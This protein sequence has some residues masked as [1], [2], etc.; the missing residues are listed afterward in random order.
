M[1]IRFYSNQRKDEKMFDP[2]AQGLSLQPIRHETDAL[3]GMAI[4]D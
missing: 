1:E 2:G 4:G 3:E